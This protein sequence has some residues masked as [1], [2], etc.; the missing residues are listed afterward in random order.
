MLHGGRLCAVFSARNYCGYRTNDAA[1][2][3]LQPHA[4]GDV[5]IKFKTLQHLPRAQRT[6]TDDLQKEK[7]FLSKQRIQHPF[8]WGLPAL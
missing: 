4:N 7:R 6:N 3:V 2:V 1:L 8:H 5:H